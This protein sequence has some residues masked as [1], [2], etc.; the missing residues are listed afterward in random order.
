MKEV[1][2]IHIAKVTY[3][4]EI[5]AKKDIQ[6]YIAA[7]ERYADDAELLSDI[8]I[9]ITELLAEHGV[10]AGGVITSADVAAVRAQLGE[11]SDF[12]SEGVDDVMATRAANSSMR[13]LYRDPDF[14]VLGG[15]LA[16]IGQFFKIDLVW[17][18]LI[19]IVLFFASFGTA[20]LVYLILWLVI[21]P[22]R[23]AAEKLHMRGQ[24]ATLEAIKQLNEHTDV[25]NTT[26]KTMHQLLRIVA[27]IVL[28][29]GAT[30]ALVATIVVTASSWSVAF[31][32]D[33]QHFGWWMV[34]ML[35]LFVLAGL[36]LSAL[37]FVLASAVLRG[38]WNNRISTSVIA[39][40]IAGILSFGGG[41]G[42][43]MYGR[44]DGSQYDWQS[45]TVRK[46]LPDNF[47]NIKRVTIEGGTQMYE[48]VNVA[49]VVSDQPR[50]ELNAP[51]EIL[52]HIVIGD[53]GVSA[54]ISVSSTNDRLSW[55]GSYVSLTVYGP[56]LDSIDV[57]GGTAHYHTQ[58]RQDALS[59]TSQE[60]SFILDGTY[61]AVRAHSKAAGTVELD[62]AT[63]EELNVQLDGG[64][65]S[66]GVV[67]TLTVQQPDVCP[68]REDEESLAR[69]EI[70]AV[71]S[72]KI[73][74]NGIERPV[75]S[76]KDGCGWVSIGM[77]DR[78]ED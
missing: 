41:I 23:T 72:D 66:A 55:G 43:I 63:V 15:V 6:K 27:G 77:R 73:S 54:R 29:L 75:K 46:N 69:L 18:R 36:L 39:I 17:V 26:A 38:R 44:Y 1:T 28:I 3:D 45:R 12:A 9:R 13:R 67:R 62:N 65:V 32:S 70:Q 37:G 52:P 51:T 71:S 47:R 59:V 34:A 25:E 50:Y 35:G 21:P 74:Y 33:A 42:L 31:L 48:Q 11:P 56:A 14:A 7:L 20:A 53:D 40:T 10:S 68:A 22:A 57:K 61:G 58:T 64:R 4:I 60:S 78:G 49:Y 16:G 2:R 5:E 8:E 19:F 30:G 76:I 24:A